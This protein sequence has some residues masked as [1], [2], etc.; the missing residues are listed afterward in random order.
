MNPYLYF[1]KGIALLLLLSILLGM[2]PVQG[3]ATE[4]AP[5]TEETNIQEVKP[6]TKA[7]VPSTSSLLSQI[8]SLLIPSVYQVKAPWD[9]LNGLYFLVCANRTIDHRGRGKTYGYLALNNSATANSIAQKDGLKTISISISNGRVK[10]DNTDA[11]FTHA[12]NIYRNTYEI[13]DTLKKTLNNTLRDNLAN[14]I[15][16]GSY[17][18]KVIG[19][20]MNVKDPDKVDCD[21]NKYT[22]NIKFSNG[23]FLNFNVYET[24]SAGSSTY[25]MLIT[26]STSDNYFKLYKT[27]YNGT[28]DSNGTVVPY[29]YWVG[30]D[31]YAPSTSFEFNPYTLTAAT[32]NQI[33]RNNYGDRNVSG[34]PWNKNTFNTN[35]YLYQIAP[36]TI[37]LYKT[38]KN[39]VRP[40]LAGNPVGKYSQEALN[41]YLLDVEKC[42]NFY[43]QHYTNTTASDSITKQSNAYSDMLENS[44]TMMKKEASDKSALDSLSQNR[45]D[46]MDIAVTLL[47]FRSDGIMFENINGA[48]PN[49]T[50]YAL[51]YVSADGE[52][53]MLNKIG[54]PHPGK[55]DTVSCRIG[56]TLDHLVD[57]YPVYTQDTVTYI[58]NALFKKHDI[59]TSSSF[60]ANWNTVFVNLVNTGFADSDSDG[61]YG[62]GTWER[63]L[64]KVQGGDNGGILLY[65]QV[66]T[67]FDLAYYILNNIW[68]PVGEE[69]TLAAGSTDRYNMV[70]EELH[71]IRMMREDNGYYSFKS[72]NDVGRDL[73]KGVIFNTKGADDG[74]APGL[75]VLAD[76]GFEHPDLYGNN[77]TGTASDHNGTSG[78][79]YAARTN[80]NYTLHA[81]SVFVYYDAKNLQFTFTGDDDVYFFVN[82]VLVCDIGGMHSAVTKTCYINDYAS[83]LDL[84]DGD[85]CSFDMFFVDRHTSGINLNFSTN[86][87]LMNAAAV[88]K[89]EQYF[90]TAPGVFNESIREGSVV[91]KG[92]EI[93]YSYMLLNRSDYAVNHVS[94]TDAQL[95]VSLSKDQINLNGTANVGDLVVTY[96]GFDPHFSQYAST[97]PVTYTV[98]GTAFEDSDFYRLIYNVVNDKSTNIPF[99]DQVI[100]ISGLTEA[101]LMVLLELGIPA[102]A[103]MEIYGFHQGVNIG[104]GAFTSTV[105]TLCYPLDQNNAQLDPLEGSDK[106][107]V[108]VIAAPSFTVDNPLELVIDYGK[109]VEIPVEEL[110]RTISTSGGAVA[111]FLGFMEGGEHG[112]VM[113]AKP[114]NIKCTK[115]GDTYATSNGI[116]EYRGDHY[117][118][119]PS[120]FLEETDRVNAVYSVSAATGTSGATAWWYT[121]VQITITPATSV[122]YEAEDFVDTE[123]SYEEKSESTVLTEFNS[124]YQDDRKKL[125]AGKLDTYMNSPDPTHDISMLFFGFGQTENDQLRYDKNPNYNKY[126]DDKSNWRGT[127]GYSLNI[128]NGVLDFSAS[129]QGTD[130][131]VY[132]CTG[133]STSDYTGLNYK[134]DPDDWFEVRIKINDLSAL[135]NLTSISFDLELFR[136]SSHLYK[137]A[138]STKVEESGNMDTSKYYTISFP[139]PANS[140]GWAN[141]ETRTYLPYEEIGT[142]KR[143]VFIPT[144]L[145]NPSTLKCSVDYIYI[146]PKSKMPSAQSGH[147]LFDYENTAAAEYRYQSEAY[148]GINYDLKENWHFDSNRIEAPLVEDGSLKL[149]T[150]PN[151]NP[152]YI[153]WVRTGTTPKD[154]GLRYV[155][156]VKDYCQVRFKIVNGQEVSSDSAF[157]A[158][159]FS[160]NGLQPL[161]ENRVFYYY[162]FSKTASGDWYTVTFPVDCDLWYASDIITA[163][164]IH[165]GGVKSSEA[166]LLTIYVDYCYVGPSQ[167]QDTDYVNSANDYYGRDDVLYFGFNDNTANNKHYDQSLYFHTNYDNS[168]RWYSNPNKSTVEIEDGVMRMLIKAPFNNDNTANCNP[169]AQTVEN[170]SPLVPALNYIPSERD[171]VQVRVKFTNCTTINSN[172]GPWVMMYFMTNRTP[173][174]KD[175]VLPNDYFRVKAD[176]SIVTCGEWVTVTQPANSVF[177]NANTIDAIRLTFNNLR[178]ANSSVGIVEV[179]YIYVG[180]EEYL[181]DRDVYGYD[182]SYTDDRGLSDG[183]SLFIKGTGYKSDTA[184]SYTQASFSFTGTG[185]DIISRTTENQATIRVTVKNPAGVTEKTKTVNLQGELDLYQIPVVS[186]EDLPHGTHNVTI[187]VNSPVKY[188]G[189]LAPLSRGEEFYLDAIR[190]YDP[191]DVEKDNL[192]SAE[193]TTLSYYKSDTEA[194]P[195]VKEIR[196]ILI[197]ATQFSSLVGT[198]TGAVYVD[199]AEELPKPTE[200]TDPTETAEPTEGDADSDICI[201]DHITYAISTYEKVGPKNEVYLSKGQAVAFKLRLNTVQVPVSIDIGAKAINKGDTPILSVGYTTG[202]NTAPVTLQE[203]KLNTNT[204]MYYSLPLTASSFASDGD[205]KYLYLVI[206]NSGNDSVLSITDLKFAYDCEPTLINEDQPPVKKALASSEPV[207][208]LVDANIPEAVE[209]VLSYETPAVDAVKIDETISMKHSLNL[210]S[211]ISVN[212]VILA[213]SLETYD[214]FYLDCVLYSGTRVTVEPVLNGEYY[215]FTLSGLTAVDIN[216][217]I[218]STLYMTK[219]EQRYTSSTDRYSVSQYAYSQLGKE[220]AS[221]KLKSL[222]ANLLR[223]GAKAQIYKEYRTNHLATYAMTES[224]MHYVTAEEDV[225]FGNTNLILEDLSDPAITWVGKTLDLGTRVNVKFVFSAEDYI[226]SVEDLTLR[227]QYTD[228]EG[229]TQ[230]LYLKDPQGYNESKQQYSFTF[231]GLLAAELRSVLS[232]QVYSGLTPLSCSMVYSADTYGNNKSGS[233]GELCKAIFA[234]S[235]SAKDYFNK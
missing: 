218:E 166:G 22:Y 99:Q 78:T 196:D 231:S 81:E 114:S 225:V 223:Y 8:D 125:T 40:F 160:N 113:T 193:E 148:L 190:I 16:Y 88:T 184:K 153:N 103:Q 185:F 188:T 7:T 213:E 43:K 80:Y 115:V 102:N 214:S 5:L 100:R 179:D 219:G 97:E 14:K 195:Y 56:L 53:N 118:F 87:E 152:E 18:D 69:D 192:S 132:F 58:A 6:S 57:G 146:G 162:D 187:E 124:L 156:S 4:T 155:P 142:V 134:P 224:M 34:W 186:I 42:I 128:A 176:P 75:N 201:D 200:S 41:G 83:K 31:T 120:R 177:R 95:G 149:I 60:D 217:V 46:Y 233:L 136:D 206:S 48:A 183:E 221:E 82:G 106:R 73:D 212:Y 101:Q 129:P 220:E 144:G 121:I 170:T 68:R 70:V 84:R 63:T 10:I 54:I 199:P 105:Q 91:E 13:D 226:G 157:V 15:A 234:Y 17:K 59:P 164:Q 235:D 12:V 205:G 111:T 1:R 210:A 61:D 147:L 39:I 123:I 133:T 28:T 230:V 49:Y 207:S 52:T 98:E 66:D 117:R 150:N 44:I 211:D 194:Y 209:K 181:P 159:Y 228:A 161:N 29:S 3:N 38:L 37:E 64:A 85:I 189:L 50:A 182:H 127:T 11:D 96:R 203:W 108:Q 94:F 178:S 229:A 9:N 74:T 197:S 30:V 27:N 67:A 173:D 32:P 138:R 126:Y 172:E 107:S 62:L 23:K 2:F 168:N 104:S 109:P 92:T 112:T 154:N 65:S 36:Q 110:T 145:K 24:N 202:S 139:M 198:G 135:N 140:G 20:L 174:S 130:S 204:A 19:S 45:S 35:W 208:F 25:P 21:L 131:W 175:G 26:P 143:M 90:Y 222:C 51:S 215:Y 167:A 141:T 122:Y 119:T 137:I 165:F 216:D 227:V 77:S 89:E 163:I 79:N 116:Y 158:L 47:D 151:N 93:G 71:T 76:L 72:D 33:R 86:I 171:Y 55:N 232:V 191:I 180:P 169:F